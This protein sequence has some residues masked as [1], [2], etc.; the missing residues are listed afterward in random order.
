MRVICPYCLSK[1][2]ITSSNR[3]SGQVS[4][5]YCQC[6]NTAECAASFVSTVAYKHT[7]NPPARTT[8]EIAMSLVNR[9]SQEEKTKLQHDMAG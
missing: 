7:L 1:A 8:S 5:L 4:D 3:L 2:I 6:T 9:L